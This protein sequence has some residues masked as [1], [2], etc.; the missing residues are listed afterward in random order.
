MEVKMKKIAVILVVTIA[1]SIL[2]A[3]ALAQ[4]YQPGNLT[5][6]ASMVARLD[7]PEQN[8]K[9][10][11]YWR[12]EKKIRLFHFSDGKGRMVLLVHGGPGYPFTEPW[13]GLRLINK[14]Y[15]FTYYHQR[16][17]GKSTRP[18]KSFKTDNFMVN[19]NLLEFSLG[20]QTQI[21]DIERIRRITGQEKLILIGHSFGAFLSAFYAVE[22]PDRVEAMILISPADVL[23]FPQESGGLYELVEELLPESMEDGYADFL[24]RYF[25]FG[26][27][28]SK[29]EDDLVALNAEF[30][31]YY[32]AA[33]ESTG[34]QL[35][36][37]GPPGENG[38]WMVH[39][40]FLSMGMQHDYRPALRNVK[41][42]VLII[43][44]DKDLMPLEAC[45]TYDGLF[46]NSRL[47]VIN[48]AGHFSFDEQPEQFAHAVASFLK[49]RL[50]G[51][52]VHKP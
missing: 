21:A 29:T 35:P 51:Q 3:Y 48:N 44:G 39:A 8:K 42:P 20:L 45:K 15:E 27:I 4:S 13:K 47:V 24:E 26:E 10:K 1:A 41:A 12:V 19:A 2:A 6:N 18:I 16:G 49:G 38:G 5:K 30:G 31:K 14:N 25:D 22:F 11:D 9:E 32:G 36:K 52:P 34:M 37:E 17:C 28:F 43:H 50:A 7:P 46:P 23:V 33:Y 40:M